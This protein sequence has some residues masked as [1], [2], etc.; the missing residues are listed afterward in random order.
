MIP[1]NI[2][3]DD[4][5]RAIN[6]IDNNGIPKERESTKFCLNYNAKQYPPK[7]IIS[8][9]NMFAN[10]IELSPSTF[11]GGEE[12]NNFLKKLEFEI[13]DEISKDIVYPI[14]SYS[15]TV[16]S[17]YI[18]VKKMDNRVFYIMVRVCLKK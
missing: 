5:L 10:G 12:S 8:I 2:K 18:F 3:K 4:V 6:Y 17:P 1:S 14:R 13:V 16:F 15:W 7:Y 11:S 9:A